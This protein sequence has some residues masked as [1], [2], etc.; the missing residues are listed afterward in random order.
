MI[1]GDRFIG[2]KQNFPSLGQECA[3][4]DSAAIKKHIHLGYIYHPKNVASLPRVKFVLQIWKIAF[5]NRI[6]A[7][8]DGFLTIPLNKGT[9]LKRNESFI[10]KKLQ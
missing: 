9:F 3:L 1:F 2:R 6:S 8:N 4:S 10:T 7:N 5:L